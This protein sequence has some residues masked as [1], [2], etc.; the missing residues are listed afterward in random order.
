MLNTSATIFSQQNLLLQ[1]I[2]YLIIFIT[3]LIN[4]AATLKPGSHYFNSYNKKIKV[5]NISVVK[6]FKHDEKFM[7]SGEIA[8]L[9]KKRKVFTFHLDKAFCLKFL[10]VFLKITKKET[11]NVAFLCSYLA[12][13]SETSLSYCYNIFMY[14]SVTFRSIVSWPF[15]HYININID[16][17]FQGISLQ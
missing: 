11:S 15:I 12:L 3:N 2:K 6:T 8:L 13:D 16:N 1:L 14:G 10:L 17:T 5:E 7:F 9:C 4:I